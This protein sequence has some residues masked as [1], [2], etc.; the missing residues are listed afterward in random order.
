MEELIGNKIEMSQVF[1]S[2][3]EVIPVTLLRVEG[4]PEGLVTGIPVTISGISKG[5]GFAGV[6]KRHNFSGGPRT[7]G[8]SDRQRAPGSIG[9]TTTPGR[10]FKGKKMAGRM[11][12]D[13]VTI[14]SARLMEVDYGANIIKI[15]GPLPGP[16]GGKIKIKVQTP[17]GLDEESLS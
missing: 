9:M 10:V 12:G 7:H 4:L 5:K 8:Q 13:K 17:G 11:G 6:M 3:G 16:R 15:S 2:S 14:K 1:T